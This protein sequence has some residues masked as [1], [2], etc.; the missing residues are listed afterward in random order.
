MKFK[1]LIGSL[2]FAAV[3]PSAQ[4]ATY[5]FDALVGTESTEIHHV[6]GLFSDTLSFDLGAN[7]IGVNGDFDLLGNKNFYLSLFKVTDGSLQEIVLDTNHKFSMTN[8]GAGTYQ[9]LVSGEVV[10]NNATGNA[11]GYSLTLSAITAPVPEPGTTAMFLAGLGLMGLI[12][13][14]RS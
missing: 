11:A 7:Q 4:A 9:L 14:R 1:R 12:A 8:L 10:G 3:I 13:R 6:D 2:L 5:S